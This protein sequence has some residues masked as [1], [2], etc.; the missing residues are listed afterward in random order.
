[1]LENVERI[2]DSLHHIL[3]EDDLV[4]EKKVNQG[5]IDEYVLDLIDKVLSNNE[6]RFF[7]LGSDTTEVNTLILSTLRSEAETTF[8]ENSKKIA[9]RLLRIEKQTQERYQQV[10]K[11]KKGSL[12][13]S[14]L[15]ND[16]SLYYLIAK[17]EHES[18]LDA[19]NLKRQMGLPY[20]KRILK[21]G[22]FVYNLDFDILDIYVSD[23]NSTMAKY[24]WESFFELTVLNSDSQNTKESF[25][26]IES[27]LKK[28]VKKQ[29]PT[30]Y[31]VLRNSL[32]GY[33]K[34]QEQF[35][36]DTMVQTVFGN[37][38]PEQPE[39]INVE[40]IKREVVGLPEKSKFDRVFNL[41]PKEITARIKKS[42]EISTGIT[43]EIKDHIEDIRDRINLES[44]LNNNTYLKIKVEKPELFE[45]FNFK[46]E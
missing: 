1:M 36:F 7:K 28:K 8:T 45:E 16:N 3:I 31:T 39:V 32:I 20:D 34:S 27:V 2:N 40:E 4:V 11:L 25:K 38:A 21:T 42:Y 41:I 26:S 12:I 29:S 37:Y 46:K 6:N 30:D 18:F 24:W 9:D 13:Q 44:D 23:S 43:L 15:K 35:S 33:F 10:T 19:E 5:D 14:Y 17:V 22:I